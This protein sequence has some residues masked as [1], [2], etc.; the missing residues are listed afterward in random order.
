MATLISKIAPSSL[1][2]R[3]LR[4][5]MMKTTLNIFVAICSLIAA[6]A[7]AGCSDDLYLKNE[8]G[9]ELTEN[10]D[11]RISSF[12]V[13]HSLWTI[14]TDQTG[15]DVTLKARNGGTMYRLAATVEHGAENY[16][17]SI[18]IPKDKHLPDG[19]YIISGALDDG[20][21]LGS[22]IE[23]TVRDEMVHKVLSVTM[24]YRLTG[25]GTKDNPYLIQSSKDF[26]KLLASLSN[27]TTH[28]AGL[29]FRQTADFTAPAES[30]V[31]DGRLYTGFDFAGIYDGQNHIITLNYSGETTE[32]DVAVGLFPALRNGAD[33]SNLKIET[34]M[35]GVKSSAGAFAGICTGDVVLSNVHVTGI[36][37]GEENIGAF[38]GNS[39]GALT[40]SNCTAYVML[41]G[42]TKVGG[43][44][45]SAT[46]GSLNVSHFSSIY[47]QNA[48][49]Y[50]FAEAKVS[51]VG[52]VAGYV[53]DC[54]INFDSITI[55]HAVDSQSANAEV[56]K[57]FN[58][59]GGLIGEAII[60][61][62][63]SITNC[64]VATP[65][66]CRVGYVGGLI[67]R[68]QLNADLTINTVTVGAYL[69]T[70]Q[71]V[72]GFF[73]HVTTNG[74]LII[75]GKNG[76]NTNRLEKYDGSYCGINGTQYVGGLFGYLKGSV[77]PKGM[78]INMNVRGGPENIGGVPGAEG[79]GSL[80]SAHSGFGINM[81]VKGPQSVGG[82]AG[83][84]T[85]A[86]IEGSMPSTTL[87]TSM[88]AS[89][90][91]SSCPITVSC[92]SVNGQPTNAT[93][94]GGIV[95]YGLNSSIKNVSFSGKVIGSLYVGGVVGHLKIESNGSL[96]NCAN[97]GSAVTN[98]WSDCTGGV[99][100]RVEYTTGSI[101]NLA[102]FATVSGQNFTGGIIGAIKV[103][104]GYSSSLSF[105]MSLNR[106]N[107]TGTVNVGGCI[108]YVSGRQAFPE[109]FSI[110]K[111]GN[112][113]DV[114]STQNGNVGGIIGHG[115]RDHIRVRYCAN[116]GNISST[117]NS[118]VGGI[119][120]RLGTNTAD[121]AGV[122]NN[123]ELGYCCNRGEIS[124]THK[125]SNVGGILGYQE[126]G[127]Q[128]DETIYMTHDCYN[129]GKISSTEQT[130]DNGGI[131]GYVDNYS[132][133][134]RCI[135]F[136]TVAKGNG[137]VG[138]HKDARKW[139]HHNLFF[140]EGTAKS[141]N[142]T[143]FTYEERGNQSTF[144][145]FDFT[146]IWTIAPSKNDGYPHLR[147]CPFQ[148]K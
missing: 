94:I 63:S 82:V 37:K 141:W 43:V 83:F 58:C 127:H 50:L 110:D 85:N 143:S 71:Y 90:Y 39:Q 133:V 61:Q 118:K 45:G 14:P 49:N 47:T 65:L 123:M 2:K 20:T 26:N 86:T 51:H 53:S 33:I 95:G 115:D 137:A 19:D 40:V 3:F 100:G 16:T 68:A 59:C 114:K 89:T 121:L 30:S 117:G 135:S 109:P 122:Y 46:A 22:F 103:A 27:D 48:P 21:P 93:A 18:M 15:V 25:G 102:N 29:Y 56:L 77:A 24:Q 92:D 69:N 105:S 146:K 132:E 62:P 128:G 120:G 35:S 134:V 136:A 87:T 70:P 23:V 107:V 38:V 1:G 145:G 34:M 147:N 75:E 9:S 130:S 42:S 41:S 98:N 79:G 10:S 97:N 72:G 111:F 54:A 126:D 32:E 131:V 106:G 66:T 76:G 67:G 119:A 80:N 101:K 44:V 142:C 6:G 60:N 74:H 4:I 13:S 91:P 81:I 5:D 28:A 64:T 116:H 11:F 108:G 8:I 7:L 125:S 36:I 96:E 57:T 124:S 17:I 52:G 31:V 12:F 104:S 55:E 144:T 73:G 140:L 99:A 78:S 148:F 138:T 139:F 129:A 112:T 88:T 84:A 113:G